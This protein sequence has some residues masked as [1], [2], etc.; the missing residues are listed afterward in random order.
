M[1]IRGHTRMLSTRYRDF[2]ISFRQALPELA[3]RTAQCCCCGNYS[4]L[5]AAGLRLTLSNIWPQR[6]RFCGHLA[7]RKLQRTLS[8]VES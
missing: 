4:L 8:R 2:I 1:M 7:R 3:K 6:L 5:Q